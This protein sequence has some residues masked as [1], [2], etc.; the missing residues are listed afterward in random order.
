MKSYNL[1]I[2]NNRKLPFLQYIDSGIKKAECRVCSPYI[3]KFKPGDILTLKGKGEY[4]KCSI[5]YLHFY[6][7]FEEML[8]S[9]GVQNLV[10]FVDNFNDA[11]KIYNSFPGSERVRTFG[12]CAIGVKCLESKLKFNITKSSK[13]I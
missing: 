5:T 2:I 6:R 8:N 4:V 13:S 9:E 11:L 1:N 3:E 7:N 10:P 12:C